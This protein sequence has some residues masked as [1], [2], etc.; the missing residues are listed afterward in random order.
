MHEL[1]KVK[2]VNE[3]PRITRIEYP[4]SPRLRKIRVFARLMDQSIVLPNG[5][6]IGLDPLIGLIPGIGDLI[7]M[8]CSLY[9]L[10]QAARLGIPKR[11]L[12]QMLGNI[13]L[14]ALVGEIPILGDIFDMVWKSNVRNLNLVEKHYNPTQ[15]ERSARSIALAMISIFLLMAAALV[16]LIMKVVTV[17]MAV[18]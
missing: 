18:F 2:S 8:S 6:R 4:E 14:E 10:Y 17:L 15:P 9:L 7:G 5:F 12:A 3:P 13:G 1:E 11:V 16:A